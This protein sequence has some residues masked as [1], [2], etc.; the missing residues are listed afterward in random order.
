MS[1]SQRFVLRAL[2]TTRV[3]VLANCK[4]FLDLLPASKSWQIEIAPLKKLRTS[5]QN[6]AHYAVAEGTLAEFCGLRGEEELK[7]L[8]RELCCLYFGAVDLPIGR[9]PKRT[10]TRNEA[11]ERDPISTQQMSDFYAFI[12]QQA[13]EIGCFIPDPDPLWNQP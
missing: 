1:H 7:A 5:K 13:A 2:D 6:A 10:T 4:R 3:N 12:Q 11:G 9:R 8:H